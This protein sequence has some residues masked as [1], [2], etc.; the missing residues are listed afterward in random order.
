M[1][2]YYNIDCE[3]NVWKYQIDYLLEDYFVRYTCLTC[4]KERMAFMTE[5]TFTS[6][7]DLLQ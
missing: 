7:P 4:D 1:P 2:I 6:K 3:F 5:L